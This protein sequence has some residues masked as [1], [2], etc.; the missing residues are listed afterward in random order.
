MRI[1]LKTFEMLT[2]M[3]IVLGLLGA[4]SMWTEIRF[5]GNLLIL[6]GLYLLYR[7]EA[8]RKRL[9]RRH[10]FYQRLGKI[11]ASNLES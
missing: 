3:M 11:V 8:E 4:L 1:T 2:V 9:R 5:V 6:F 7:T 10:A